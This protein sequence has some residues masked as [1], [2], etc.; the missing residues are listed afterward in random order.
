MHFTDLLY[1][2]E[3]EQGFD[4]DFIRCARMS[5]RRLGSSCMFAENM[6]TEQRYD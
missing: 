6:E 4:G 5:F 2:A 1:D 3:S